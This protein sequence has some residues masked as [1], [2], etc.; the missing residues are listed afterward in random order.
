MKFD[1]V[2][3]VLLLGAVGAAGYMAWRAYRAGSGALGGIGSAVSE[4]AGTVGG[5]VNPTADTNLAYR[6]V[7]AIGSGLTGNPDFTLGGAA[8]DVERETGVRPW[9]WVN[10]A[11]AIGTA[12]GKVATGVW[13]STFFNAAAV[14]DARQID[15]IIERQQAEYT[16]LDARYAGAAWGGDGYTGSW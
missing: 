11:N 2:K 9:Q 8:Y 1:T 15:R 5:W 16:A 12:V 7:N 4:A 6:G 13:N 3:S 14:N 10:P